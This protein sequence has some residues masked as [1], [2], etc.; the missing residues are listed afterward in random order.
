MDAGNFQSIVD[1]KIFDLQTI[2]TKFFAL[3]DGDCLRKFKQAADRQSCTAERALFNMLDD[4]LIDIQDKIHHLDK[5]GDIPNL[6]KTGASIDEVITLLV[7]LEALLTER[8]NTRD[9]VEMEARQM[10]AQVR[11]VFDRVKQGSI[12]KYEDVENHLKQLE[13]QFINR[14]GLQE[15]VKADTSSPRSD[16]AGSNVKHTLWVQGIDKPEDADASYHV[17][18]LKYITELADAAKCKGQ[19]VGESL[20]RGVY[21]TDGK[22]HYNVAKVLLS[23]LNRMVNSVREVEAMKREIDKSLK[24]RKPKFNDIK[25][26]IDISETEG[27]EAKEDEML[28]TEN[29]TKFTNT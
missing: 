3:N 29:G 4:K 27:R 23:V 15:E 25:S 2:P 18:A 21:I 13:A 6:D 10:D 20:G 24:N 16:T 17:S 5:T 8:K 1:K 7:A 11:E 14:T 22:R 28:D 12:N 26:R 19:A 9:E